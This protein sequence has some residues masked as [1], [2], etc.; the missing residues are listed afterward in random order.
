MGMR[1]PLSGK[2]TQSKDQIQHV[3]F[4]QFPDA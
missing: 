3:D 4:L 1:K 2:M